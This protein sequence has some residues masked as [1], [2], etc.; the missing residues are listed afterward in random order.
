MI[1]HPIK[2][3]VVGRNKQVIEPVLISM[4]FS[5][6]EKDFEY[7]I[8]YGGDG[9]LMKAE[10]FYPGVPKIIL[11]DSYICKKCSVFSNEVVLEKI[12]NGEFKIEEMVKLCVNVN[13]LELEGINDI[14]VH[15]KDPR[16]AMRYRISVNGNLIPHEVIGD[17][18]VIA[19]PFGSTGYYRSITDSYFEIGIGLA[20][21]NSIEQSDHIIL[22]DTAHIELHLNRGPAIV[23]A[24]N[25]ETMIDIESGAVVRIEKSK[26]KAKVVVPK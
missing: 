23:Y 11:R 2:V 10:E 24:D 20:F 1:S 18:V 19:T 16:H 9:T 13:G 6:V 14:V 8:S 7:V 25:H 12:K 22:N 15:N 17:G 4:G 21:N 3:I 26:K 5:V